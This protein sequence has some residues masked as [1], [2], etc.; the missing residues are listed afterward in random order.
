VPAAVALNII[1]EKCH[2][3]SKE[4]WGFKKEKEEKKRK[5]F[6]TADV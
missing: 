3:L 6:L 5:S 2:F 1:T 4:K